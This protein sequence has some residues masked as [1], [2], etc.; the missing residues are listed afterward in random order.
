[1]DTWINGCMDAWMH[2]SMDAWMHG[3]M[4]AW[5]DII[6]EKTESTLFALQHLSL[7]W[8]AHFHTKAMDMRWF[9]HQTICILLEL[10]LKPNLPR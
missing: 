6:N 9:D 5:I 4:D 10:Q 7:Y 2:G 3:C 8:L 1:M